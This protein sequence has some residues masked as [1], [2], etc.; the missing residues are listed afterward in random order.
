MK[1]PTQNKKTYSEEDIKNVSR[2]LENRLR[3][4]GKECQVQFLN[5]CVTIAPPAWPG[6]SSGDTFYEAL[7]DAEMAEE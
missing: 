5:D 2:I 3:A 1:T 6:E 7:K 4:L